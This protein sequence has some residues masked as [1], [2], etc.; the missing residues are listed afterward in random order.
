MILLSS[1]R[2]SAV[3]PFLRQVGINQLFARAVVEGHIAGKVWADRVDQPRSFLVSH[4]YGMSLLFG[5]PGQESLVQA[6][7]DYMLNTSGQRQQV[8]WLQAW[9]APWDQVLAHSLGHL[10]HKPSEPPV[11]AQ[12]K[13][14]ELHTRVN[15]HFNQQLFQERRDLLAKR[16]AILVRTDAS[17]FDAMEGSV[18]PRFF[19]KNA[20]E[21]ELKGV[22]YSVV[23]DGLPV[24]TAYSAFM[25]DEKL[26]I[27][28]ETREAY[29]GRGFAQACA[30]ALIEYCLEHG[31]EPVWACRGENTASFQLAQKLGFEPT[32]RIPYYRL[33][34]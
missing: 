25:V 30:S 2:Y 16:D 28:I 29:R 15:F 4:P 20:S 9:P 1:D 26:E 31:L 14:V 8:E 17:L 7:R 27:G 34:V 24:S 22:G 5:D 32:Y 3:D 19:W 13:T 18:I 10:L 21:F 23:V 6:V 11:S 33:P 12:H